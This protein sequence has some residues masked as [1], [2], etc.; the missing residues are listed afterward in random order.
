MGLAEDIH[1]FLADEGCVIIG[2]ADLTCLEPEPRQGFD[3]GVVFGLTYTGEALR[4]N[5]V[6]DDMRAYHAEYTDLSARVTALT[7]ALERYLVDRGHQ[8]LGRPPSA[9]TRDAD[10]RTPLPHKTVATLA[11]LGW[12]GKCATL[13]T[14]AAGSG[15]RLGVVLTDAPLAHGTPVTTSRCPAT[16][17]AC[18][19]VCP[20]GAPL[21]PQW[22]VGVDRAEF[23]DAHACQDAARA[24]AMALLGTEVILCGLCVAVCPFTQHAL[25]YSTA[26]RPG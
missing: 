1:G 22:S 21:G 13:V 25:G 17:T 10:L 19:D 4:A 26:E 5:L 12:I 7:G 9:I 3:S 14:T 6:A 23:F 20:T 15:L 2:F 16:C 18:V 24:R 8:A 11:G